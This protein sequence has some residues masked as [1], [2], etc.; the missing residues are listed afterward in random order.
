MNLRTAILYS[1][2]KSVESIYQ[3][4]SY[5]TEREILRFIA[6]FVAVSFALALTLSNYTG[7]PV[8]ESWRLAFA[9]MLIPVMVGLA[10]SIF[11]FSYW[12]PICLVALLL[13]WALVGDLLRFSL[14]TTIPGDAEH[15]WHNAIVVKQSLVNTWEFR[16]L[17]GCSILAFALKLFNDER[18]GF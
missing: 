7:F 15:N 3:H 1:C 12:K 5:M 9:A 13:V 6:G 4:F 14:D 11:E 16:W 18:N 17:I 10:L 2:A 8:L